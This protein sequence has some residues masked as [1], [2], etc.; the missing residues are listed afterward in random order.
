MD[1]LT[2]EEI[3]EIN[4]NLKEASL[5]DKDD[6]VE[7]IEK[8]DYWE[9]LLCFSSQVRGI[10]YFTKK[11]VIFVGGFAGT[12]SFSIPYKNI[13]ELKKCNVGLF[14]PCG[15]KVIFHDDKKDKDKS[16]KLSLL[17]RDKWIKFIEEKMK[18]K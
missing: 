4:D 12:T 9:K 2:Q 11:N 6:S 7:I 1:G 16:Y 13:K 17:K 15:V 8:G 5:M 3:K 10:Y 18:N 14:I